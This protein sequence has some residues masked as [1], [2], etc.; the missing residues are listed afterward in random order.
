MAKRPRK[1]RDNGRV[2]CP[3][4]QP[5]TFAAC[6]GPLIAGR[7]HALTALALMRSRYSAYARNQLDYVEATW[8]P[9]TRPSQIEPRPELR[10]T[11]L[12]I[13][14][15]EAGGVDDV[16]G[17][18]RFEARFKVRGVADSMTE[19]SA[20]ERVDGRWLYVGAVVADNASTGT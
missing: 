6:C 16:R 4:G 5:R 18:V 10:W 17:E 20:F 9:A 2:P 3:C 8:H 15:T 12:E 14:E 7:A 11:G 19:L 13:L 1:I